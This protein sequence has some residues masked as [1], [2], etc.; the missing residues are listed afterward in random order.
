M[1]LQK[2]DLQEF[3]LHNSEISENT[4]IT[5]NC[6]FGDDIWNLKNEKL[7]RRN[8]VGASKLKF[9][10]T[11][12]ADAVGN[13]FVHEL[14]VITYFLICAP[15]V[16]KR[17]SVKH[18]TYKISTVNSMIKKLGSVVEE[19]IHFQQKET[20]IYS[21]VSAS[22][23]GELSL[24][25]FEKIQLSPSRIGEVKRCLIY[26]TNPYIQKYLKQPI[27]WCTSDVKAL[28]IKNIPK[29]NVK[30][31]SATHIEE[32]LY[33]MLIK[34]V[35]IDII[36]FKKHLKLSVHSKITPS[37]LS[38]ING[39]SY[40][41]ELENAFEDYIKIREKDKEYALRSGSRYSNSKTYRMKFK[42]AYG[43]TVKDFYEELVNIHRAAI[44]AILLFTGVR[45]S[46]LISFKSSCVLKRND[47]Y[48]LKGTVIKNRGDLLPTDIDEWVAI[49]IV[50]DAVEVLELYQRFT[51]NSYLVSPLRTVYLN[52]KNLPMS[53][54]AVSDALNLYLLT[55]KE[56]NSSLQ[57]YA[58]QPMHKITIHRL[59]HTLARQLIKG[60][61]GLPYISYHLKH[62]NSAVV[63]YNRTSNV[64]LGYGGISKE[65]LN[66]AKQN[67][68]VRK[69]LVKEIY[70]P[71]AVVA[72]GKNAN[73]FTKRKKDYFQGLMV[74]DDDI[75][76]IIEDLKNQSLPFLDVGLGYCGG[77][78]DILFEDGT[79][80][81]PPCIGQLKCN[82][83]DCSNAVIPKSKL[84]I[85][86]KVD[87]DTVYKLQDDQF[88]YM[89]LELKET[90][91]RAEYVI[92]HFHS[93]WED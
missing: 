15:E 16:F 76:D 61:L 79:K 33:A 70:H 35:T 34:Q 84:P 67:H 55:S 1:E 46:E 50:R 89:E 80:Q 88:N 71:N 5:E 28:N 32:A 4:Y 85:W 65:I 53:E 12:I 52:Q 47:V 39:K 42:K 68:L 38:E 63:A 73:E 30:E 18:K 27:P 93:K 74:D 26:L 25:D 62:I 41:Y 78:K 57:K 49:P 31:Y 45:Y 13:D 14:K 22:R 40:A 77:R 82:P 9:D 8:S 10:W 81:P 29:S 87:Q 75:N 44:M 92:N 59:R 17:N 86:K 69:E 48:L 11:V 24:K 83:I 37:M 64:T 91:K 58:N 20:D 21:N 60:R 43:I 19:I 72:G 51:F 7:E 90:L 36:S 2:T 23:F 56:R 6:V 3:I 54:H 66:S